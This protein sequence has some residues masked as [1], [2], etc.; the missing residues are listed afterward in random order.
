LSS[1]LRCLAS[2]TFRY[3][4]L[5][6]GSSSKLKIVAGVYHSKNH[7]TWQLLWDESPPSDVRA[8]SLLRFQIMM[9]TRANAAAVGH[10]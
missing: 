6:A 3:G 5:D 4:R 10:C 1:F 8:T 2:S 7:L 9:S